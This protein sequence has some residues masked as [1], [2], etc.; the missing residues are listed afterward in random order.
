MLKDMTID[1][2]VDTQNR[3]VIATA[4]IPVC[5]AQGDWVWSQIAKAKARCIASDKFDEKYGKDLARTRL[6]IKVNKIE[7]KVVNQIIEELK[8]DL[9]EGCADMDRLNNDLKRYM[10]KLSD[11]GVKQ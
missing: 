3:V 11:L 6:L 8:A 9:K 2:R 5:D 10:K 7:R 1:Y 4:Y